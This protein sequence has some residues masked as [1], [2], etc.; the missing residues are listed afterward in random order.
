MNM[1]LSMMQYKMYYKYCCVHMQSANAH[2]HILSARMN[3]QLIGTYSINMP[4]DRNE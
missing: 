1:H 4:T 2:A 3:A